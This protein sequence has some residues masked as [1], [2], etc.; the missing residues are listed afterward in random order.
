MRPVAAQPLSAHPKWRSCLPILL[1]FMHGCGCFYTAD[2]PEVKAPVPSAIAVIPSTVFVVPGAE[3]VMRARMVDEH[4]GVYAEPPG[5]DWTLGDNLTELSRGADSIRVKAAGA[6]STVTTSVQANA[7]TQTAEAKV[8]ILKPGA[9]GTLDSSLGD[10]RAGIEP[11]LLLIDNGPAIDDSQIAFVGIG[12][13]GNLVGNSGKVWRF[14][15]DQAFEMRPVSFQASKDIVDLRTPPPD[16][17]RRPSY[18]IWIATTVWGAEALA[19]VDARLAA[20][21]FR[22]QRTGLALLNT[23]ASAP[24]GRYTLAEGEAPCLGVWAQLQALGIPANAPSFKAESLN[25]VYV[26]DLLAPPE[27]DGA[28]PISTELTGYTCPRDPTI[29]TVILMSQNWKGTSSLAHELGHAFGLHEPD[30]GHTN[31][32]EGFSYT[33]MMWSREG[34]ATG[35]SRRLFTLGQAFRINLDDHSWHPYPGVTPINCDVLGKNPSCPPLRL[36]VR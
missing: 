14:A 9:A 34:D 22:H 1:I 3:F 26:D 13:L 25:V 27:F 18:T 21:I 19:L 6:P 31:A 15:N 17:L 2:R 12:L 5:L 11:D 16:D 35:F 33:N 10:N 36:D 24:A 28:V 32:L 4:N 30:G 20:T 8:I 23:S 7:G 29:G